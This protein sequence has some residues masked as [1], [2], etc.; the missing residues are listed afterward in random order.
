MLLVEF[1]SQ[2][3]WQRFGLTL[4]HFLWQGF[5]VAVLAAIFVRAFRVKH[6][7]G[8]YA[9]HL[10]AFAAMIVCPLVT[11]S[12]IDIPAGLDVEFVVDAGTLE[13]VDSSAHAAL[14]VVDVLPGA[15][16]SMPI[17]SEHAV[18]QSIPL[19]ERMSGLLDV[20][21]PWVLVV[22]MIGVIVLSV[23]LLAG[24]IGIYRWR[25]NLEPLPKD[26]ADRV[27][28]LSD[29]LGMSGFSRVFVSPTVLQAMAVG[30]LKPMVLLPVSM[31]TQMDTEMLEAVI[32]HELAH[33]RRFDLWINLA[34]RVTE[35][36]LFYHPAVW[37]LSSC[38]RSD[39]E[40][41]CDAMAVK[42]TGE[43]LT[44]AKTLES[45]S[46]DRAMAKQPILAAGLGQ[47]SKPT[48]SRVRHVLGLKPAQQ[49]SPF[50]VAGV[51]AFLFLAAIAIP[52]TLALTSDRNKQVD[53]K[54]NSVRVY[55][56]NCNVSDFPETEDFSTPES[57]YAAIKRVMAAEDYKSWQ[58]VSVKRLTERLAKEAK[59]RK[60][61]N[62]DL[63][64]SR[65]VLNAH[66]LEVRIK[67]GQAVVIAK[68]S[69]KLTSKPIKNP[70]DYRHLELEDGKWLNT[71]ENR[72]D[73]IEQAR[74]K[75]DKMVEKQL[76]E[77]KEQLISQQKYSEVIDN[78]EMLLGMAE[79]LFG[80][81]RKADYEKVLSYYD[82]Q[83]GKWRRDGW[84]KL[85]LDYMVH[86]DWLS[87]AVW[88]C[89]TFKDNP[90]V[91]V[92]LGR[93]F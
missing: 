75:F 11:F 70:I 4:V 14:P 53:I 18:A 28:S 7:N 24:F 67:D 27:A 38:L 61:K 12:V 21:M 36:L 74:E 41:C 13:G 19:G 82:E 25:N 60:E 78:P 54:S 59:V 65:V 86:T 63:E 29:R 40:L 5:A 37:W 77:T 87:F 55:Q 35:T 79:E 81:L 64:W 80:K 50:W 47:N 1:L 32:A 49:N 76:E 16:I 31:V 9:A 90:I 52:T 34:Q 8:R 62:A 69:E 57:A 83:T 45:V 42:I 2:P 68:L 30:Y 22:W 46:R 3:I 20:S 15:D 58:R 23:R 39:R 17:I 91:S 92:E 66:V 6:G 71:G 84:K 48:L 88:V 93:C 44:Y 85:G 43:R 33:I 26:L 89:R 56:V 72:Y 51:I 73:S 10:L